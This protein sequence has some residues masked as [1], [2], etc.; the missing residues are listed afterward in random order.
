MAGLR[1]DGKVKNSPG[2]SAAEPSESP[3]LNTWRVRGQS[4][5]RRSGRGSGTTSTGR[6]EA[7]DDGGAG[8]ADQGVEEHAVAV[9][10]EDDHAR[11]AGVGVAEDRLGGGA[12]DDDGVGV[13][14]AVA[15]LG[16]E[17]FEVGALIVEAA[18]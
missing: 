6:R 8:A 4:L 7:F 3:G 1:R 13:D 18:W 2:R 11:V 9:G 16:G 5:S 12:F 10:A 15:E 17:F 14:A